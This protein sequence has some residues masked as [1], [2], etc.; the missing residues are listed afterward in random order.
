MPETDADD[1]PAKPIN[2]AAP[3]V[4]HAWSRAARHDGGTAAA[5][6]VGGEAVPAQPR[7][8]GA[9]QGRQES[10]KDWMSAVATA[11]PRV[12]H[13]TSQPSPPP[14]PHDAARKR[15]EDGD[16]WDRS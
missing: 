11:G 6:Q 2:P 16:V 12:Q 13:A 3:S 14:E 4:A 1:A 9:Q 15:S 5:I 7:A 10:V 8:P